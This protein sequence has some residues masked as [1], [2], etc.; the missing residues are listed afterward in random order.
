MRHPASYFHV[1]SGLDLCQC[2]PVGVEGEV[3][4]V[5][6][7]EIYAVVF[8][9]GIGPEVMEKEIVTHGK[10][11]FESMGGC[12]IISD[13]ITKQGDA[14]RIAAFVQRE[15]TAGADR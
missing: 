15:R 14:F 13:E 4:A 12:G 8:R 5:Q 6:A 3:L 11:C 1:M 7:V 9:Q 2:M 10:S